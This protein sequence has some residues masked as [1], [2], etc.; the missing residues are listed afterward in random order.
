MTKKFGNFTALSELNLKVEESVIYGLLG[1][2]GAGK[3]TAIRILC[4]LIKQT[5]GEAYIFGRRIPDKTILSTIGY[6]PQETALYL[7]PNCA[8]EH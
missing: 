6:M 4:G 2:N 1:P 3:T 5:S 8:P 7:G